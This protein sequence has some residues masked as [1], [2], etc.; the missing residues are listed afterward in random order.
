[1]F[2]EDRLNRIVKIATHHFFI[3]LL[4]DSPEYFEGIC[5]FEKG[6]VIYLLRNICLHFMALKKGG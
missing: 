2:L 1:M 6:I 3:I 4:T 5:I